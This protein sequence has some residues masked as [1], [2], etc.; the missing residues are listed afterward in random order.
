VPCVP[1]LRIICFYHTRQP[2]QAM[3]NQG[4]VAWS[5]TEVQEWLRE[6]AL[7]Q[8]VIEQFII[9]A[10]SGAG[11]CPRGLPVAAGGVTARLGAATPL[12]ACTIPCSLPPLR[13]AD[14]PERRRLDPGAAMQAAAGPQDS[15]SAGQ[16]W[17]R[18]PRCSGAGGARCRSPARCRTGGGP[19]SSSC[20]RPSACAHSRRSSGCPRP[21]GLPPAGLWRPAACLRA[22]AWIL[23]PAASR[24]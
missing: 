18:R 11:K 12:T 23:W 10:V 1:Y 8:D 5:T 7:P 21:D 20:A 24:R 16:A 15:L 6:L 4:P 13:R 19:C 14:R 22:A 9:N 3:P 2:L 17:H